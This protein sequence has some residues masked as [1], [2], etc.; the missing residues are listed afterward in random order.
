MYKISKAFSSTSIA[1]TFNPYFGW[2]K[3][4]A[5]SDKELNFVDML[6]NALFVYAI[7][8]Y[9]IIVY[10]IIAYAII[11]NICEFVL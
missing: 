10:A 2:Y 9:A 4:I 3:H 1:T 7:I 11:V 5:V 6:K 8:V